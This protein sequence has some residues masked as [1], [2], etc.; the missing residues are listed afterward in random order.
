MPKKRKATWTHIDAFKSEGSEFDS[1]GTV[2]ELID[3]NEEDL[4]R[5]LSQADAGSFAGSPKKKAKKFTN[6]N[7]SETNFS[8][9]K[10]PLNE[11]E[12]SE[13]DIPLDSDKSKKTKKKKQKNKKKK[14]KDLAN[15]SFSSENQNS[16]NKEAEVEMKNDASNVPLDLTEIKDKWGNDGIPDEILKALAEK[17]FTNPTE[18]QK[19]CIPKAIGFKDVVGAAETGK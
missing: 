12:K 14:K 6:D 9:S 1:L 4:A 19:I 15:S 17:K 11:N 3:Y 2:E 8:N 16:K 10:E 7:A 13:K 18:I 5:I